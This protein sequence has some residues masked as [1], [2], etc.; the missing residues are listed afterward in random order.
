MTQCKSMVLLLGLAMACGEGIP[1]PAGPPGATGPV[2]P[3]LTAVYPAEVFSGRTEIVQIAGSGTNFSAMTQVTF[4]DPAIKVLT[5]T[6]TTEGNLRLVVE[7]G[8][9]AKLS[10]H[11][12]SVM[13]GQE[14]LQLAGGLAVM[15]PLKALPPTGTAPMLQQGGRLDFAGA[16]LTNRD[17]SK[18]LRSAPC[19]VT[20]DLGFPLG[21]GCNT[22]IQTQSITGNFG[23]IDVFAPTGPLKSFVL[24]GQSLMGDTV[25]YGIDPADALLPTVASRMPFPLASGTGVMNQNFPFP[26]ATNLYK[27]TTTAADRLLFLNYTNVGTAFALQ[28]PMAVVMPASGKASQGE[29]LKDLRYSTPTNQYASLAWLPTAGEQYVTTLMNATAGQDYS[30]TLTATVGAGTKVSMV[31][32]TPDSAAMPVAKLDGMPLARNTGVIATDGQISSATDMDY[33]LVKVG[34][35]GRLFYSLRGTDNVQATLMIGSGG[36]GCVSDLTGTETTSNFSQE[37]S[38]SLLLLMDQIVCVRVQNT[39]G[40]ARAK[41]Y[42]LLLFLL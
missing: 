32:T 19:S 2:T 26:S 38:Q 14:M 31:D 6:A 30:H 35:A 9:G 13:T 29:V 11:T 15:A 10:A 5:L 40:F 7:V 18:L 8:V 25:D 36:M 1:G 3:V 37:D 42:R 22:N 23:L 39:G 33:I 21:F 4:D 24:R 20:G 17:G 12:V 34:S 16:S 28:G 41:P 27:V